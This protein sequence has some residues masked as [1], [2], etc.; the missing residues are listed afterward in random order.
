M[1]VSLRKTGLVETFFFINGTKSETLQ[2]D[3]KSNGRG[4]ADGGK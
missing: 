3:F 4:K 1:V 2:Y